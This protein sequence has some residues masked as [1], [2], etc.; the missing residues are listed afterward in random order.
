MRNNK[1]YGIILLILVTIFLIY[2]YNIYTSK[3]NYGTVHLSP[4]A[5]KGERLWLKNNCNA[6][7]QLYGLGGYL[8]P[9]LT[10]I[11]STQGKPDEYIKAMMLSS[12]DPMPQFNFTEEEQNELLQFLKAVDKTGY[13]PN[14]QAN[15]EPDG[16]VKL[17]YKDYLYE[18]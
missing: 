14:K 17:K 1:I 3:S 8:G 16:W 12:L 15:I 5:L 13:F 6:C 7:H 11:C 4:E 2:N 18:K 9:D 10:N